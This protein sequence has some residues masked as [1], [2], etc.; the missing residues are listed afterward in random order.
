[1]IPTSRKA[2]VRNTAQNSYLNIDKTFCINYIHPDSLDTESSLKS[3]PLAL[4]IETCDRVRRDLERTRFSTILCDL[5]CDIAAPSSLAGQKRQANANL[6]HPP[7]K[8]R[9]SSCYLP[10][11]LAPP[12]PS[13][14]LPPPQT[15]PVNLSSKLAEV[16]PTFSPSATPSPTPSPV[17]NSQSPT[18]M[19]NLLTQ[20]LFFGGLFPHLL[21]LGPL[22][23]PPCQQYSPHSLFTPSQTQA[24]FLP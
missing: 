15:E 8:L 22:F 13:F 20:L 17:P 10:L 9:R 7:M 3:D 23:P 21:K 19:T 4:L 1:M 6:C 18:P 12:P 11:P 2:V 16:V 14:F 5:V 24:A